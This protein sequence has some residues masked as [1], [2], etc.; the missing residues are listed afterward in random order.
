MTSAAPQLI[1]LVFIGGR[2]FKALP[3]ATVTVVVSG[4]VSQV[5]MLLASLLP[6]KVIVLLGAESVPKYFPDFLVGFDRSQLVLIMSAAALAFFALHLLAEKVAASSI[7]YGVRKLIEQSNKLTLFDHQEEI[8][9]KGYQRFAGG[10]ANVVFVVLAFS[11]LVSIYPLLSIVS[12]G[13]VLLAFLC[14]LVWNHFS[15]G[16]W[17]WTPKSVQLINALGILGFLVC[18]VFMVVDILYAGAVSVLWAVVSLL[19]IRQV[20]KGVSG[21]VVDFC[22]LSQYRLPLNALFFHEHVLVSAEKGREPNSIWD[23][24]EPSIREGWLPTVVGEITQRSG[25]GMQVYWQQS[26]IIDIVTLRVK[27]PD[28][29]KGVGDFLVSLYAASRGVV[30]KHEASLLLEINTGKGPFPRLLGADQVSGYHCHVYD[31]SDLTPCNP[32]DYADCKLKANASLLSMAPP[33]GLVERY[34]RSKPFFW[35]TLDEAF[36]DRMY[37]VA[38]DDGERQLVG[39]FAQ[40]LESICSRLKSLPLVVVNPDIW[41]TTLWQN[42][43]GEPLI[44]YW[45]RWSLE[46]A[47]SN[48]PHHE[49]DLK[50]LASALSNAQSKRADLHAVTGDELALAALSYALVAAFQRQ[51]YEGVLDLIVPVLD[52]A[53]FL[54][55]KSGL[56]PALQGLGE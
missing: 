16:T 1:W 54:E 17:H 8:A 42:D 36:I 40:R 12:L 6:L 46:P 29:G 39:C 22:S 19:L 28:E 4:L 13:Y 24:V 3:W 31:W 49:N 25:E 38:S 37:L 41:K 55:N 2:F 47:G 53:D 45:G 44:S 27:L 18:F 56:A 50:A 21:G 23:M 34:Q 43:A 15:S 51:D 48:W 10:V 11:V 32:M 7:G 20:L 33:E 9:A 52:K 30:A 14:F 5:A 35:K 26:G